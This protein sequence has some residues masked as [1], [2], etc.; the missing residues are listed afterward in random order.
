MVLYYVTLVIGLILLGVF[1]AVRAKKPS[2]KATTLKS[3]VST[4]FMFM[5]F[6]AAHAEGEHYSFALLT[7]CGLLLGLFGDIWLDLKYLYP[8]DSDFWTFL[9]F[10]VFMAGHIFYMA[11]VISVAPDGACVKAIPW[12]IAGGVIALVVVLFG[13]KPMKLKYGKFKAISAVY[14]TELVF[15]AVFLFVSGIIGKNV[16]LTVMGVGEILFFLS[17]LVL[18]GT[19]FGEGKD[20]PV[21]IVSNY[22]L[23]YIA[24]FMIA[25]SVLWV[26][27]SY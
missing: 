17:D 13:E 24:Q 14:A 15:S 18:S 2:I 21:D 27:M 12:A 5:V 4:F 7:A 22:L 6:A 9:G 8:K 16:G 20:R 26:G 23:Y 3:F 1:V 19:Y 10:G 11:A 25:S